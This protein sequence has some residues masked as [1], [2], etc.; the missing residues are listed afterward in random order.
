MATQVL[1]NAHL[2]L[3]AVDLSDEINQIGLSLS[4]DT[5]ED[6]AMG[7]DSRSFLAGLRNGSFTVN[8]NSDYTTG[9]GDATLWTIYTGGAAVTFAIRPD[10]GA[11][12]T[13]NPEYSGS[14]IL[15]DYNPVDGSVGDLAT[16][17]ASFQ[18]TGDVS[19]ATA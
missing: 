10:A 9:N 19:R 15:T 13:S 14:C 16:T 6:T 8:L 3:N 11:T 2:T 7:D 12:S 17:S 5:P 4:S 18:V 1:K